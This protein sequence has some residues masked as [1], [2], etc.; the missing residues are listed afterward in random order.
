MKHV[1]PLLLLACAWP[2]GARAAASC[3]IVPA[4]GGTLVDFGNYDAMSGDRDA[5]GQI[6][7]LCVPD[8]LTGPTVSYTLAIN[9]GTGGGS[10]NPR[11]MIA[12]AYGLNYNLFLDPS[13]TQI[14]GDGSAGTG[15][16]AGGCAGS[17]AVAVYGR[18][19]GAQPVPAAQYRDELLATLDF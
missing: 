2:F 19:Y 17:C 18:I 3:T 1:V 6:Q 14:F 10:F 4:P 12:G 11:R 16:A 9:S 7:F 8:L 13:R 15:K 5:I